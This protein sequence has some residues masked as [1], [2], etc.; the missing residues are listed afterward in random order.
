MGAIAN[1]IIIGMVG[2]DEFALLSQHKHYR[3]IDMAKVFSWMKAGK[4][5]CVCLKENHFKYIFTKLV[6]YN[7]QYLIM[8][9]VE[10][11]LA[12]IDNRIE[13]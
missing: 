9:R 7:I 11:I 3:I 10:Y 4:D 12:D 13:F 6:C 5:M 2:R 8:Q 1:I